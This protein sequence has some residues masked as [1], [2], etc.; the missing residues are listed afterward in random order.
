[1]T[2]R[3]SDR[4]HVGQQLLPDGDNGGGVVWFAGGKRRMSGRRMSGRRRIRTVEVRGKDGALR[5]SEQHVPFNNTINCNRHQF[6]N[7]INCNR[8]QQLSPPPQIPLQQSPNHNHHHNHQ[9]CNLRSCL[10][11][12]PA[13]AAAPAAVLLQSVIDCRNPET[14]IQNVMKWW[15]WTSNNLPSNETV[16]YKN[17]WTELLSSSDPSPPPPPTARA[18]PA[19]PLHRCSRQQPAARAN[20]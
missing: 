18:A 10:W 2:C 11:C 3:G 5:E 13:I 1:M 17:A 8:H 9:T 19:M 20:A 6:N 7:T 4:E 12:M 14:T 15:S 16:L